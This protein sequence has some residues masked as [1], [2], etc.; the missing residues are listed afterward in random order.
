MCLPQRRPDPPLLLLPD[1]TSASAPIFAGIVSLL[2]EARA[3][4]GMS[5]LGFANPLLYHIANQRPGAFRDITV[6]NN[7]CSS[8]GACCEAGFQ[9]TVGFDPATGLGSPNYSVLREAVVE[10]GCSDAQRAAG[11]TC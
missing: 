3:N 4:A 10:Y 2:N 8:Q 9:A 11:A 5:P 7:R 6:G 1:G